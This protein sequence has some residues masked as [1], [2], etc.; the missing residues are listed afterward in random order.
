M[1]AYWMDNQQEGLQQYTVPL[2]TLPLLLLY[3]H[4]PQQGANVYSILHKKQ[5]G[6]TYTEVRKVLTINHYC[7]DNT[8]IYAWL[9]PANHAKQFFLVLLY[10]CVRK[11]KRIL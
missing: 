4:C 2:T 10:L 7:I 3:P 6:S 11:A 8:A 5:K 9:A 1:K